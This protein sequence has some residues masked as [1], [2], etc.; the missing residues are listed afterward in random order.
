MAEK[1][2]RGTDVRPLFQEVSRKRMPQGVTT[3]G[4]GDACFLHRT[5]DRLL[6]G[7]RGAAGP[8][9]VSASRTLGRRTEGKT[10][11]HPHSAAAFGYF[12]SRA[13]GIEALP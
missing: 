9:D 8:L 5:L 10:Y 3:G 7:G 12:R 4:L 2:L 11:C 1:L 13:F 6:H